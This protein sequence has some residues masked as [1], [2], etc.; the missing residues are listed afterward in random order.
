MSHF[1]RF[2]R[3]QLLAK[4]RKKRNI[5]PK[6]N[7]FFRQLQTYSGVFSKKI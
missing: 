3:P 1:S 5:L 4:E 6:N 7:N 2:N